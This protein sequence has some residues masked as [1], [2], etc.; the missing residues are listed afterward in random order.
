VI[1]EPAAY[2]PKFSQAIAHQPGQPDDREQTIV[3]DP[4]GDCGKMV[5]CRRVVWCE[6]GDQIGPAE[7]SY[8]RIN[9]P[10]R[11]RSM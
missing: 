9:A 6:G 3:E 7:C 2:R 10:L 8:G 11:A 1:D 4:V 5:P